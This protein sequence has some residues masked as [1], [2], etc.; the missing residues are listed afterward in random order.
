MCLSYLSISELQKRRKEERKGMT[1][2]QQ[3]PF[4]FILRCLREKK[5]GQLN[6]IIL[7]LKLHIINLICCV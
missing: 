5:S 1:V 3:N 4:Y 7:M 2:M 6:K